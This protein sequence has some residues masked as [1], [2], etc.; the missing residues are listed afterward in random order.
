[1]LSHKC[2]GKRML[3]ICEQIDVQYFFGNQPQRLLLYTVALACPHL[4]RNSFS[5]YFPVFSWLR[6][7]YN[8]I[9]QRRGLVFRQVCAQGKHLMQI[10]SLSSLAM[11]Y[12]LRQPCKF[13]C[14]MHHFIALTQ[15]SASVQDPTKSYILT[16]KC[17]SYSY[18]MM[19]FVCSHVQQT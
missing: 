11:D 1:M 17:L 3:I 6:E 10:A 4:P 13:K 7:L 9:K 18:R 2:E 15:W 16:Q 14:T 19:V 8:I 12:A 5:A